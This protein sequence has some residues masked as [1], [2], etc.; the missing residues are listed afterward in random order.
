MI[1]NIIKKTLIRGLISP[2]GYQYGELTY[3]QSLYS[4]DSFE[5][6]PTYRVMDLDGKLLVQD[7]QYDTQKLL[8]IL[9]TMILVD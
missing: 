1:N 7:H 2:L 5:K 9:K 8:K 6:L 4:K 3:T